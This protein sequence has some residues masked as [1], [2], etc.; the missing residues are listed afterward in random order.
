[1]IP[2]TRGEEVPVVAFV[3]SFLLLVVGIAICFVVGRRY[4]PGG[5]LTW[6]EAFVGGTFVFGLMI[7][8]YGVVPHQWL[9]LADN[10]LLWRADRIMVGVSFPP[11]A[12]VE[13]GQKA[14]SMAGTG[15]ILVSYQAVRDAIAAVLYIVFLGGQVWLWSVWQKRGKAKPAVALSSAFGRPLARKA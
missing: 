13:F 12:G 8:A 6:G 2:F 9:T 4:Q 11:D 1:V 3:V 7:L 14:N 5:P 15:R 10:D